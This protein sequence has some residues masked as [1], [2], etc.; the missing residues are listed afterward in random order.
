ME[1]PTDTSVQ[2]CAAKF[3]SQKIDLIVGVGGGSS[4][5]LLKGY[6]SH[7]RWVDEGFWGVETTIPLLPMIAIPTTGGTGSECQSYALISNDSNHRKW[8]AGSQCFA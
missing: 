7:Q 8:P 5:I 1:N 3:K 4:L 6:F 2:E